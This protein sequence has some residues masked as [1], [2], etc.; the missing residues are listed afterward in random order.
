M[1]ATQKVALIGATVASTLF[2][3]DD[4]VGQKIRMGNNLFTI[5]GLL[6]SKGDRIQLDRSD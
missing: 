6:Q 2:A 4:P 3:N 1:T 5:I